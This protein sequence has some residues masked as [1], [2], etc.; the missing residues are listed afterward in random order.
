MSR[1]RARTSPKPTHLTTADACG[2]WLEIL[3][4][5]QAVERSFDHVKMNYQTLGNRVPHL[6]THLIPR[7]A[8]DPASNRPLPWTHLDEGQR[9]LEE[10]AAEAA[11]LRAALS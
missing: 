8:Y 11:R 2:Y 4:I 5:G 3:R 10:I 7:A 6:H 9:P 1:R